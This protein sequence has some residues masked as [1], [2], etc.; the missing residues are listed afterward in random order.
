MP[1][2]N[3]VPSY[4]PTDLLF[5][6]GKLDEVVNS[7]SATYADRLGATRRTL[8]GLEAEFPN[9]Q[10]NAT[11]AAASA[12]A[13]ASSATQAANEA[14][15]ALAEA[16]AAQASRVAAE[17]AR[18]AAL[19]QAGVFVDEPTGRAAVADGVAFKVQGSGDVA[20]YEYRRVNASS[21]TLIA[22]YPSLAGIWGI[23]ASKRTA[24]IGKNKF[25]PADQ[26]VAA[27]YA[28]NS[29]TGG[30]T[31]TTGF[32]ATGFIPVTAGQ[33]Y[34]MSVGRAYAW[35]DASRMFIS[36][37]AGTGVAQSVT[38]P[39]NAKYFRCGI[40][41]SALPT[42][43]FEVGSAST[44]YKAYTEEPTLQD[45]VVAANAILRNS[46]TPDRVSFISP[47]KNKFDLN[48]V[49]VG[50][51]ISPAG[52]MSVNATYD[53]S[54]Y[55]SVTAGAS[56]K[57]SH[58]IRFSC[59]FDSAMNVVAG[60]ITADSTTFTV[61]AGVAFV[62][63][64]MY[65]ANL[66]AF[67]LEVGA[68]ATAFES[69]RWVNDLASQV[70][71]G[72]IT[73]A[74]IAGKAVTP[75]K[76][77]FFAA[78][79]NL[80]D[81]SKALLGYYLSNTG[82][83]AASASYE[84]S[85]YIAITPGQ[86]YSLSPSAGVRFTCYF[87]AQLNVVAGGSS[88][89]GVS[90]FTAPAGAVWVR[91]TVFQTSHDAFQFEIGAR[92]TA[93][94]PFGS[95]LNTAVLP[96]PELVM[97][98]AIFG[99]QGRECNV[100]FDNLHIARSADYDHDVTSASN[101]GV[102]QSERW[103]W[104]PSAAL[105]AGS[106]VINAHNRHTGEIVATATTN[107][108]AASSSAGSGLNK[109]LIVIGDSLVNAGVIT[110]TL[111]DVAATDVMGVTLLGTRGTGS[112]KHEGRGGWTIAA[113]TS[114]YSDGT[115]GSNP[116]WIGGVVNFPQYLTNNSLATPDWVAIHLGINDVFAQTTDA[117]AIST[118]NTAF[119]ALDTLIASIK[120]AGAGVK[121][122]LML[123][124]PPASSQDAFGASYGTGQTRWRFKRNLL[125]WTQTLI[126]RYAGQEAS[127]IY[128]APTNT[129]LDTTNNV[130]YAAA[131]PVNSRSSVQVARQNNGVHPADSGY[132]QI[133]DALWAFLKYYA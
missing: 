124:T 39:A 18:D 111:L 51:Y 59:Y 44:Q 87:D 128:I 117:G 93:F 65:H 85:D 9:A 33:A 96:A 41:D 110:Q 37:G 38:A 113:Y 56:Y 126:A 77:S 119:D 2:T 21:S 80:F 22:V 45:D 15:S 66:S 89:A 10:A 122:A 70:P 14:D 125:L 74:A 79:R 86:T 123:P 19:I 116:F 118:A 34:T 94:V 43:Q 78:S 16:T 62:R 95:S 20:A 23:D 52:V 71:D 132:Q 6:A 120:N 72:S 46:I 58:N 32:T 82:S 98:P 81:K 101:A 8:A 133:G 13:A 35:Y 24:V 31:A 121:V 47:G 11:A 88:T 106:L 64:T 50:Q 12:T 30:L 69:F 109:K 92:A 57:S 25:N 67:Q 3:P 97:P 53:T 108:R 73:T 130:S 75:E 17:A 1:T 114:N 61:P 4:D 29:S 104:T 60:G 103:T 131:A 54:D 112:N 36:G 27:G 107:Q 115:Y 26:N 7:A 5:N 76:V 40:S 127:R 102:Q 90:S 129:A 83:L 100:Y 48:A 63:I 42:F 91:I 84:V 99:V 105:T 49:T 28:I 68:T 55:I